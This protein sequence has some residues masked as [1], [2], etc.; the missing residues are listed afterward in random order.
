MSKDMTSDFM[1]RGFHNGFLEWLERK[2]NVKIENHDIFVMDNGNLK[3]E[4]IFL[5][6]Y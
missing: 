4:Q 2:Y 1:G 3:I 5:N 6:T